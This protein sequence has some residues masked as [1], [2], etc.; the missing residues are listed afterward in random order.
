MVRKQHLAIG[1]YKSVRFIVNLSVF[2]RNS[3]FFCLNVSVQY[4]NQSY[5]LQLRV[6]KINAPPIFGCNMDA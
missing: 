2:R 6:I 4:E 5:N 1:I 3:R